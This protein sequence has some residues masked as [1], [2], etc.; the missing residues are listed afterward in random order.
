MI[1]YAPE[2]ET[3]AQNQRVAT[4]EPTSILGLLAAGLLGTRMKWPRKTGQ[5]NKL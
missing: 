2:V 1:A 4:P 3:T 5:R